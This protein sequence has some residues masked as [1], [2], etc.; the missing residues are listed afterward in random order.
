MHREVG[1]GEAW[2]KPFRHQVGDFERVIRAGLRHALRDMRGD[3]MA[4]RARIGM[5]DDDERV[6]GGYS[7]LPIAVDRPSLIYL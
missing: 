1:C 5:S 7:C 2:V 4:E 3:T 6:H